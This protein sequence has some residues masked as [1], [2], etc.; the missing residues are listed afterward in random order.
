MNE[1]MIVSP[2]KNQYSR[3]EIA[4]GSSYALNPAVLKITEGATITHGFFK[5]GFF[6]R[7]SSHLL[8]VL[9]GGRLHAG[10]ESCSSHLLTV[11]LRLG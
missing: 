1:K 7:L 11:F 4:L 6:I 2:I 8:P 3:I 5:S 9:Y 10:K